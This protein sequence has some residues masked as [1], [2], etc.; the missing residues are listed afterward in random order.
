VTGRTPSW[1]RSASGQDDLVLVAGQQGLEPRL[2]HLGPGRFD[3][4]QQVHIGQLR[5]AVAQA[6][7]RRLVDLLEGQ[8]VGIQEADFAQRRIHHPAQIA[9]VVLVAAFLGDVLEQQHRAMAVA[10]LVQQR[11][12]PGAADDGPA[13][14]VQAFQ[15]LLGLLD[16]TA[17]HRRNLVTQ[18][19]DRQADVQRVEGGADYLLGPQAPGHLVPAVPALHGV[20]G[21]ETITPPFIARSTDSRCRR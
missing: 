4:L 9:A 2:E 11:R 21:I 16:P 1:V 7:L 13:A 19:V 14:P 17:L 20:L 10:G 15:H 5:L 18:A 6:A 3:Q 12:D 8:G